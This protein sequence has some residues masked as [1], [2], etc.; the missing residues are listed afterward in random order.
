MINLSKSYNEAVERAKQI[1]GTKYESRPSQLTSLDLKRL[2]EEKFGDKYKIDAWL[3]LMRA[4]IKF[5]RLKDYKLAKLVRFNQSD[6]TI[7]LLTTDGAEVTLSLYNLY[8]YNEFYGTVHNPDR[9]YVRGRLL[10]RNFNMTWYKI[11]NATISSAGI[12]KERKPSVSRDTDIARFDKISRANVKAGMLGSGMKVKESGVN[13]HSR[14]AKSDKQGTYIIPKVVAESHGDSG[15]RYTYENR[16]IRNIV[17]QGNP[18][19]ITEALCYGCKDVEEINIPKSVNTI[20]KF[21]FCGCEKLKQIELHEGIVSIGTAA[22]SNCDLR[23]VVTPKTLRYL[24]KRVFYENK[25]LKSL[26]INTGIGALPEGL[27]A[28]CESL[29]ELYIP[30]SV[31]TVDHYLFTT[32]KMYGGGNGKHLCTITAPKHLAEQLYQASACCSYIKEIIY[33]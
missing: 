26:R 20:E 23:S 21:A 33:Y 8:K 12:I 10:N 30:K 2:N 13:V 28:G 5:N 25:N 22:F 6:K 29:T 4:I 31:K 19:T 17:I 24:G 1:S 14:G 15:L 11:V 18:T 3:Y 7:N 16:N 27:L 32:R 9:Q